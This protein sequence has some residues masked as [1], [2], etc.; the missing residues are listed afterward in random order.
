MSDDVTHHGDVNN[1]V[2]VGQANYSAKVSKK[3]SKTK[4]GE[5]HEI[6]FSLR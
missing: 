2:T 3:L 5:V 4:G 6:S 1:D